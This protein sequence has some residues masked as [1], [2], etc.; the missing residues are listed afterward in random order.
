MDDTF[1]KSQIKVKEIWVDPEMSVN[2]CFSHN[3][4]EAAADLTFNNK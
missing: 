4:K 3:I 1:C 2:L